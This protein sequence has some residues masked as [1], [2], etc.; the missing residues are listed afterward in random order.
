MP[1]LR[2]S[3]AIPRPIL[4]VDDDVHVRALIAVALGDAGYAVVTAQDGAEALQRV[5]QHAP[6]LIVLD[7]N[8]P[9]MDAKSFLGLYRL[10]AGPQVPVVLCTAAGRERDVA[11]LGGDAFVGKP[12]DLDDLVATVTRL[13]EPSRHATRFVA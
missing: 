13:L 9:R 8:L 10:C 2:Q 3:G 1:V 11:D 12:F 4:V 7:V 5:A 6:Q